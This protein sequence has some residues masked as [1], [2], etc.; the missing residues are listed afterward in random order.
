MKAERDKFN[1]S[2]STMSKKQITEET[3][4]FKDYLNQI[5]KKIDQ[6]SGKSS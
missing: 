4:K 2:I 6:N 1:H 5:K 3:T